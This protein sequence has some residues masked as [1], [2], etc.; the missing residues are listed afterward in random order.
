MCSINVVYCNKSLSQ[1]SEDGG[2]R[3]DRLY[4]A[5]NLG[6]FRSSEIVHLIQLLI[7]PCR[8][9]ISAMDFIDAEESRLAF[10]SC[11]DPRDDL[12]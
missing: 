5:V 10:Q 8:V 1:N 4:C 12:D 9:S 7:N 11:K 6:T 2:E 3:K